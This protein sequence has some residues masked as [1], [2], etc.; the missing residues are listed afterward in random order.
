LNLRIT[1]K[2]D[3]SGL[4]VVSAASKTCSR[5]YDH[6]D[7]DLIAPAMSVQAADLRTWIHIHPLPCR[8][9]PS[10]A[11]IIRPSCAWVSRCSPRSSQN[12]LNCIIEQ[13][14]S[15]EPPSYHQGRHTQARRGLSYHDAPA[16]RNLDAVYSLPAIIHQL[17]AAFQNV[18]DKNGTHDLKLHGFRVSRISSLSNARDVP[19]KAADSD[20]VHIVIVWA[21]CCSPFDCAQTMRPSILD[22]STTSKEVLNR[23][24]HFGKGS[25]GL[26]CSLPANSSC[27]RCVQMSCPE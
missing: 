26:V 5:S 6:G 12:R 19:L 20:V 10:R 2:G 8:A 7:E 25:V 16:A 18:S 11:P 23:V 15:V 4:E 27:R 3:R 14:D 24:V 1:L 9:S 21:Q 13:V 17:L 22:A